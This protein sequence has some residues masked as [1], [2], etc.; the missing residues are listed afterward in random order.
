MILSVSLPF[1]YT[2]VG[3]YHVGPDIMSLAAFQ[4]PTVLCS[5]SACSVHTIIKTLANEF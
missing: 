2:E 4:S 1:N 3:G 5:K